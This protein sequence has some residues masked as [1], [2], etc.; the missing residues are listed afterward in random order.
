[1]D[2]ADN[3]VS[4]LAFVGATVAF[5]LGFFGIDLPQS[6]DAAL[7]LAFAAIYLKIPFRGR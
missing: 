6:M 3:T 4:L 5:W 2:G 1:M 7:F